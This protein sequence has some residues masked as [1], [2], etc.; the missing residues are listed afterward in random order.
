MVIKGS[1]A[2]VS[3]RRDLFQFHFCYTLQFTVATC[4]DYSE[5]AQLYM[6][7]LSWLKHKSFQDFQGK[8]YQ[9]LTGICKYLFNVYEPYLVFILEMPSSV[10]FTRQKQYLRFVAVRRII[11]ER[12]YYMQIFPNN[13]K[14]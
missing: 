7:F 3:L 14:V 12:K 1:S 9:Q 13:F 10:Y 8:K 4:R 2:A 5:I 6:I 11:R